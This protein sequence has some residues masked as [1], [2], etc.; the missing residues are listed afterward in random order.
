MEILCECGSADCH[1]FV[2]M[3]EYTYINLNKKN[4]LVIAK[5]CSMT[6]GDILVANHGTWLEVKGSN[7]SEK[8]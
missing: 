5:G 2:E 3:S 6:A 7:I 4:H 8:E 1:K